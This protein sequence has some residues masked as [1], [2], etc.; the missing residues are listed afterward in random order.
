[1]IPISKNIGCICEVKTGDYEANK[2]LRPKY[3]NQCVSRLG[4][5]S[6]SE[7]ELI[8]THLQNRPDW[9]DENKYIFKILIGNEKKEGINSIFLSIDHVEKFIKNRIEKYQR[10]K[11]QDRML[12]NS[13]LFQILIH[14]NRG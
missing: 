2:V 9:T 1:M 4:L 3:V 12:F 7:V 10:E 6:K 8:A 11:Y 5:V 14:Q 13:C